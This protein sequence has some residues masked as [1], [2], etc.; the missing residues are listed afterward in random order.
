M[1]LNIF[2]A[3]A[4]ATSNIPTQQ[5]RMMPMRMIMPRPLQ[6]SSQQPLNPIPPPP[7][8]TTEKKVI[9]GEGIWNLL[10]T[11][12]V[13]V[14]E[15]DF[16][17]IRVE[18]LNH[19]YG[20]CTNLPCPECSNHAKTYLDGINFNTIQTKVDLIKLLHAFH[21]DVNYRKGYPFFPYEQ[22]EEKYSKAITGKIL[23]VGMVYFSDRIRSKKL[24]A[25][26]LYKSRL[27]QELKN[28]FNTNINCFYP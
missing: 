26:D 1:N 8:N 2:S 23:Q 18:L 24:L 5:I 4:R 22:V 19:I 20:I 13:K 16:L 9:W 6:Q 10:H 15:T 3:Q 28:W 14:K 21:N 27:T 17:R 12:S 25:S 11:L 7:S